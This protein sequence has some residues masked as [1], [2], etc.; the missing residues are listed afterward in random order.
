MRPARP[1]AF[2]PPGP[3]CAPPESA[4]YPPGRDPF[5]EVLLPTDACAP[6]LGCWF[7]HDVTLARAGARHRDAL[8]LFHV[9][10][11]V[12]DAANFGGRTLEQEL[13]W[14]PFGRTPQ[15][16]RVRTKRLLAIDG[17]VLPAFQALLNSLPTSPSG[18]RFPVEV[19]ADDELDPMPDQRTPWTAYRFAWMVRRATTASTRATAS[20]APTVAQ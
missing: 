4:A 20:G 9:A 10:A 7:Y 19:I 6:L 14:E 13:R 18:R 17:P 11:G 2:G 16:R 3:P 5:D 1:S 15:W 12:D 8:L